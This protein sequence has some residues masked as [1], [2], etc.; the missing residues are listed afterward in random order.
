MSETTLTGRE[1]E[2]SRPATMRRVVAASFIGNFVEWFDYAVYGYL[3]A[4]IALVFFPESSPTAGLLATFGVFAI[5]FIIRPVGG[6][7]WGH[8]GDKVGRRTAL[9]LSILIMS[10]STFVIALLPGYEQIGLAAPAL[11]LVVRLVQGFS[12]AGEYAGAASFL[13]EYAP[14]NRR[15]IHTS[16]VPASTATGLLLGSVM[17]TALTA[18]L[19][20]AQMTSWGWRL[21]FLLA[22][23]LG[24]IGRYIRAKLE[25]TPEFRALEQEE[26]E[27]RTPLKETFLHNKRAVIVGLGVACLNAVGFYTLLTYMPTYLSSELHLDE[28]ASFLST[29]VA[30][31]GYIGSV[32]LMG[33]LSD[34]F[35]R[36]AMLAAAGIVFALLSVPLFLL[37]G[38]A[39]LVGITLLQ[40]GLGVMLT[41]NDG[42]LPSYLAELF[43]TR[44]RYSGFA[45]SFN[46]ANALFGGTAP[47][48]ATFLI[49]SSGSTIAPAW[50]LAAAGLVAALSIGLARGGARQSRPDR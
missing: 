34:R 43:P 26:T 17:V 24:L 11:L 23:P 10:A 40:F 44:V 14:K 47:F 3:A 18:M 21:P 4:T 35:G 15:G 37:L 22:A 42:T 13:F 38:T 20:D 36:P 28:T 45:F 31:C 39:G 7:F 8:F 29:T 19:S 6:V 30:L 12:A 33:R 16:V 25:D 50:Y 41:M 9:S 5:S 46:L 48:V 1:S 27:A 32:F 49:H 2:E